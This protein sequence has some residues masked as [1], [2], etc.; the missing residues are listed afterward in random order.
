M[1]SYKN[2]S[3]TKQKANAFAIR[4]YKL[5]KYLCDEKK[6]FVIAKQILK[7]GTSIGANLAEA[8][9]GI[10]TNDFLSKIYISYKECSETLYWLELIKNVE[11]IPNEWFD[12]MYQDCKE[13]IRLLSS[14]IQTTKNKTKDCDK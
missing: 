5:H 8:E 12:S 13:L 6:E 4:I 14:S 11:L 3:V 7:S 2:K 9:C 1:I 10:S